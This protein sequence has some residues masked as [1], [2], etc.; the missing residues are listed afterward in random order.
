ML[1]FSSCASYFYP[2]TE[3]EL[4]KKHCIMYFF[5][6][7]NQHDGWAGCLA[8]VSAHTSSFVRPTNGVTAQS[9]GWGQFGCLNSG[10][11]SQSC[12]H[13]LTEFLCA[14]CFAPALVS[15]CW[16]P[17][18]I[19]SLPPIWEAPPG[20]CP[21]V[22]EVSTSSPKTPSKECT[23]TVAKISHQRSLCDP[24]RLLGEGG[25]I[26]SGTQGLVP[27][28][29]PSPAGVQIAAVSTSVPS[30]STSQ[31]PSSRIW[32]WRENLNKS[33]ISTPD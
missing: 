25:L 10:C 3:N 11:C 30:L 8:V 4:G 5:C 14:L 33:K 29:L 1:H 21:C 23:T 28:P 22:M 9:S 26:P 12:P 15:G 27:W 7:S 32:D 18:R 13:K 17:G 20:Q 31:V 6:P 16:G 19:Q 2:F 24:K